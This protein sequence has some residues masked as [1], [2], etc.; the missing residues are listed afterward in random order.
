MKASSLRFRP[1]A[2]AILCTLI[3]VPTLQAQTTA[4]T[5]PV[6]FITVTIPAAVDANTPA[7]SALSI[8]LYKT[9][10]FTGPV[11]S[12]DSSTQ[13]SLTGAAFTV[14]QFADLAAPRLVRV[15]TSTTAAHVGKFF[16]VTANTATQL[17]VDLTGTGVANIGDVLT[18]GATPDTVEIVAANTLGSVFGNA[19]TPPTLAPGA[20]AGV[21]DN[22][23]LWNG[24]T[25]DTYYW[26]GAVGSPTNIWKSIGNLN[27]ANTVIYPE[28]G[29]FVVRKA[30]TGPVDITFLGTVPSTTE[31]SGIA[32]SGSTF[33]ANRFP[34]DT[35]LGALGLH[36]LPGW[37][38]GASA[39]T[40]D[41]VFV[42]NKTAGVWDTYYWTGAVGSP[43]NI[44]KS[45]GN[46]DRS[47]TPILAG[48]GVFIAHG[49]SA[50][51]L[52]QTLP[53]TP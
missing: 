19:T 24:T 52:T 43:A 44:W 27:R 6:G 36:T 34:T 42:W 32:A 17:T 45:I 23:L 31:Q 21:A 2:A 48:T 18:A 49:G 9:A 8:P 29:V 39:G 7:S 50:L 38:A 11:A 26:T 51:N 47:S 46:L 1:L 25:W 10:D 16:L 30:T 3:A 13:F 40:A 22:V 14:N 28:D 5:V 20:S 15:K 4:T 37:T 35:T 53:Y 12:I 33:L 41:N